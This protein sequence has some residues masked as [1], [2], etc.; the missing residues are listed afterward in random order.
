MFKLLIAEDEV[1][2]REAI[3]RSIDFAAL[4]FNLVASCEDG[5]EAWEA[6]Q[7]ELPDLVLTDINMP[8]MSGLELAKAISEDPHDCRVVILTGHD[9]FDYARQAISYQVT[10][11]L[12]KPVTPKELRQMLSKQAA[13]LEE[14]AGKKALVQAQIS[15][16]YRTESL[17][18]NQLLNQ[19]ISGNLDPKVLEARDESLH[20]LLNK[21][22]FRIALLNHS[23]SV[24]RLEE[25]KLSKQDV[26]FL[27]YNLADEMAE[28]QAELTVFQA[29]ENPI[30]VLAGGNNEHALEILLVKFMENL[31]ETFAEL[32][33]LSFKAGYSLSSTLETIAQAKEQADLALSF[34]VEMGAEN[35]ISYCELS[36]LTL[37]T[38]VHS[39]EM[40]VQSLET[41]DGKG[42]QAAVADFVSALRLA[43]LKPEE[44]HSYVQKL[45][46]ELQ[47]K[48]HLAPDADLP[49]FDA[50]S[51]FN[52]DLSILQNT[53]YRQL[54]SKRGQESA[55][56]PQSAKEI[57]MAARHYI[58]RN[59]SDN[60]LSLITLCNKLNVSMSYFSSIFK[61]ETGMTFVEFLT[62]TRM[63]NAKK[64]L[65]ES[66]LMLYTVAERVGYDSAAYFTA[67]F[68]KNIGVTPKEYRKR[69]SLEGR[70]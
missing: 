32:T 2:A 41:Q 53:L 42:L 55:G 65:T 20:E 17:A 25:L 59:Y 28:K 50:L 9:R 45:I 44:R 43:Q 3:E 51:V 26:Q 52:S 49:I 69:F 61:T 5:R 36:R 18:M 34:A 33:M 13:I 56:K 54:E 27:L 57:V 23:T 24:K 22:H 7:R 64:L 15:Q 67:A 14:N 6:Y 8:N 37:Q 21:K 31:H 35:T 16:S 10:D 60:S 19:F 11:Y 30:V 38:L 46:D 63:R 39:H 62:E 47:E 70:I 68:K 1:L 66:N 48:Q 4:N 29:V 12:L 40:L 58:E